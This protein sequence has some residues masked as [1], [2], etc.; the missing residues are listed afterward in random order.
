MPVVLGGNKAALQAKLLGRLC[1]TPSPKD[2][3]VLVSCCHSYCRRWW[4]SR[5]GSPRFPAGVDGMIP[6][7]DTMYLVLSD[8]SAIVWPSLTSAH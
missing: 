8:I 6:N 1:T 7:M 5:K 3:E 4:W 2:S